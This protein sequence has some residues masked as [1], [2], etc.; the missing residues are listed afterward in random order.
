MDRTSISNRTGINSLVCAMRMGWVVGSFQ[1]TAIDTQKYG[2]HAPNAGPPQGPGAVGHQDQGS[3][4]GGSYSITH[5]D[6]NAVLNIDLQQGAVI[7]SKSGVMIH[8]AG[9]VAI[10]G[11]IKFSMRKMF[12]GGQMSETTFSGHGKVVL[13]PTLLGDIVT[14]PIDTNSN[15]LIGKD[16]YLA[17][18][19]DVRKETKSQ[20]IGK[21]LFSGED[22]FVYRVM[23]QG[24]L[25][26]TSY[27]AVDRIDV[28]V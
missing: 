24:L 23:G 21:A 12:T 22:L 18:T 4:P 20:G 5:R 10:Q 14:L 28:S 1:L 19:A 9:T 27:G 26:L 6:T 16:V 7:K 3:F 11:N 25:W 8:M 17:S 13:G 15:W 2:Q